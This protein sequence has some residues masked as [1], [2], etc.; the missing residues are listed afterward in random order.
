ML[1]NVP[2][3]AAPDARQAAVGDPAVGGSGRGRNGY[4]HL[5]ALFAE[6][7]SL[8]ADDP[9]RLRLRARLITAHLPLAQH[10]AR[11]YAGRGQPV[12]DL[13]Q[14]AVVGL[15]GAVDRFDPRLGH[16]FLAFAVPTI[17]GH[18]R[19]YFRD[20]TWS[21]RVDRR[22]KDLYLALSAATTELSQRLG[23]APTAAQ[24]A[25]HLRRP[26]REVIDAMQAVEGAYR[27]QCLD[28]L[29]GEDDAGGAACSG[30]L[31]ATAEAG[32]E[33]FEQRATLAPLL[34]ALPERERTIILL[35]FWGNQNQIQIGRRLGISQMHVSR[36]L[37]TTLRTLRTKLLETEA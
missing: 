2:A 11:R 3:A 14:V 16:D 24:L 28:R 27:P 12:E 31:L 29:I 36:L 30:D 33:A 26:I 6:L 8:G 4:G 34:A 32:F 19:R 1:V 37:T 23:R 21:I 18:I 7:G 15:I 20:F 9:R 10:I 35:R 13:E 17:T 25:A 22:V 5:V